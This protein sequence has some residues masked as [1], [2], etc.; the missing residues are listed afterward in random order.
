M[1]SFITE[2][3]RGTLAIRDGREVGNPAVSPKLP[4]PSLE[5]PRVRSRTGPAVP[6]GGPGVLS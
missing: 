4:P 1:G 2:K 6:S 5:L 3:P